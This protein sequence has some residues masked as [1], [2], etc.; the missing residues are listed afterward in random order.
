[1]FLQIVLVIS[2]FIASGYIV[3]FIIKLVRKVI[4]EF[5]IP[6]F[7]RKLMKETNKKLFNYYKVPINYVV[8]KCYD[9]SKDFL[10]NKDLLLFI[11]E[12]KLRIINDLTS[13]TKD[14]GCY[15][16]ELSDIKISYDIFNDLKSTKIIDNDFKIILGKRSYSFLVQ[17]IN[18]RMINGVKEQNEKAN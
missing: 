5:I 12:D 2:S 18:R 11:F 15:E 3:Y 10:I 1:M 8:T 7:E 4:P 14:F 16:F 9:S 13:T 6:D 17:S